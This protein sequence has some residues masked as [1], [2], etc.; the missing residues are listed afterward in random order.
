MVTMGQAKELVI[1]DHVTCIFLYLNLIILGKHVY[2]PRGNQ[3]S[4]RSVVAF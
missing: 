4:K 3:K 2:F 1:K